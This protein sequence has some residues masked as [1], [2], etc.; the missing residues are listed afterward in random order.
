MKIAQTGVTNLALLQRL[1]HHTDHLAT[2][3]QR[4]VGKLAH[5]PDFAAAIHQPNMAIS[6]EFAQRSGCPD[7]S[8][9]CS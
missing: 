9:A 8:R 7:V 1:W 5:Q 2:S 4:G 6:Q 3:P